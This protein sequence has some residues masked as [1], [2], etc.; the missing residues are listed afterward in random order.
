MTRL[1]LAGENEPRTLPGKGRE[2]GEIY[3]I[4]ACVF[5]Q[6]FCG[7][8]W[9]REEKYREFHSLGLHGARNP[10]KWLWSLSK[11]V[12]HP[13]NITLKSYVTFS[14]FELPPR[15]KRTRGVPIDHY[16]SKYNA[17]VQN[18]PR[19][20]TPLLFHRNFRGN[21][22]YTPSLHPRG[23]FFHAGF[24]LRGDTLQHYTESDTFIN[25]HGQKVLHI[26]F[27]LEFLK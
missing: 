4:S 8:T 13:R 23:T 26:F 12:F 16:L 5:F 14:S 19:K 24:L 15:F 21:F 27:F 20:V 2:T 3:I 6:G 11:R 17:N 10:T 9:H 7:V 1:P 25:L 22:H 18:S